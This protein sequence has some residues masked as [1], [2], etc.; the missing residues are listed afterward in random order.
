MEGFFQHYKGGMLGLDPQLCMCMIPS[1]PPLS[2]STHS[3]SILANLSGQD[4][5]AEWLQQ[6]Q[7]QE[8][9][10]KELLEG[11]RRTMQEAWST[12]VVPTKPLYI[13]P[14]VYTAFPVHGDPADTVHGPQG[15]IC[16]I[17]DGCGL[18]CRLNP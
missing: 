8:G 11:W 1:L 7:K 5:V 9:G 13:G 12:S 15:A 14:K 2:P 17:E 18:T 16:L 3:I 6:K 10:K 4:E